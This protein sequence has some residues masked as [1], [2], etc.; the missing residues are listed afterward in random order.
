MVELLF[1]PPE[2][3]DEELE[4][5]GKKSQWWNGWFQSEKRKE[6]A[7]AVLHFRTSPR[8]LSMV[9]MCI[10]M[11]TNFLILCGFKQVWVYQSIFL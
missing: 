1:I 9:I 2:K 7:L 4:E 3:H 10:C 6:W 8:M 11:L 5:Q